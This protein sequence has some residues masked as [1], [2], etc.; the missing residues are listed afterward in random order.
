MPGKIHSSFSCTVARLLGNGVS[1]TQGRRKQ[2]SHASACK[3]RHVYRKQG[4]AV[5]AVGVWQDHETQETHPLPTSTIVDCACR[6]FYSLPFHWRDAEFSFFPP[7]TH[8]I[9]DQ[10]HWLFLIARVGIIGQP[11]SGSDL[12]VRGCSRY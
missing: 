6:K 12:F 4:R 8:S 9:F 3:F 1:R 7:T 2:L 10:I 5:C 11:F